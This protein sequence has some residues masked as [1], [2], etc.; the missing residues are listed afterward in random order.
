MGF[1]ISFKDIIDIFLVAV[2]LYEMFRI[3]KRSGAVN[4]FWGILA[5]I[6]AWFI[7]SYVLALELTGAL[8]DRI[9]NVGALAL[10]VIFQDEIRSFFAHI[11]S[12][13]SISSLHKNLHTDKVQAAI[14][15][16]VNE[17]VTACRH[18]ART[19]TGA[20]IVITRSQDLTKY[21][22]T[23]EKINSIIS[24]RLIENIFFKNT[25]LHDGA[26][27][28]SNGRIDSA[29]CIL[30]V[31]KNLHLPQ[32]YG[33]RHRAALGL[34]EITD[35]V[36]IVVSEETGHISVAIGEKIRTVKS[37]ELEQI[38]SLSLKSK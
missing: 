2:I 37:D 18:M 29:A 20:L 35:A 1:Q 28:I 36:A 22:A 5:F 6:I 17:I 7:A 38:L 31:S 8:F 30:P 32:Q 3:L 33:L 34:T 21:I 25:P 23:G 9:I 19:K 4:L 27:F 12:R 10:I 14:E 26:L 11:G 24:A 15:H 13:F 16:N